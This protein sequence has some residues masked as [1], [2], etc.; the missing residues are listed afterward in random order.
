MEFDHNIVYAIQDEDTLIVAYESGGIACYD[1]NK[2]K[3]VDE[4]RT[5]LGVIKSIGVSDTRV[6]RSERTLVCG[7]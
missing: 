4:L 5:G 7:G 6:A 1:W 2:D 3:I